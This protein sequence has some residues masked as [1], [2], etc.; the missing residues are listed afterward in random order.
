MIIV[1]SIFL[2]LAIIAIIVLYK[3]IIRIIFNFPIEENFD[4]KEWFDDNIIEEMPCTIAWTF[5]NNSDFDGSSYDFSLYDDYN[6]IGIV[7]YSKSEQY[8]YFNDNNEP[9]VFFMPNQT[10]A[11]LKDGRYE[12]DLRQYL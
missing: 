5:E 7:E 2:A 1:L 9:M 6:I 10:V 8:K 12:W 11:L 4:L 3:T